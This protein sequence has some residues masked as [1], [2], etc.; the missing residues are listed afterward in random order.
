MDG[1]IVQLDGVEVGKFTYTKVNT[2][3]YYM[4]I[5]KTGRELKIIAREGGD[6]YLMMAEVK[7][8]GE[9]DL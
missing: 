3:V 4:D 5:K 2:L 6:G 9:I 7:V 1:Q 8:Y